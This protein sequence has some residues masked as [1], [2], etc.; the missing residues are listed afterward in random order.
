MSLNDCLNSAVQQG[1]ISRDQADEINKFYQQKIR[2]KGNTTSGRSAAKKE[3][4]EELRA[5]AELARRR[6]LLSEKARRDIVDFL[7][8]HHTIYG[9]E[10]KLDGALSLMIHYGNVG[11]FSMVGRMHAIIGLAHRSLSDVMYHFRKSGAW[12]KYRNSIDLPDLVR[13]IHG[14]AV[15]NPAVKKMA[16]AIRGAYEDL[17]QRFNA[18]G[19]NIPKRE[20]HGLPHSHDLRKI[21]KAGGGDIQKSRQAWK[22][23]IRPLLDPEMM[24]NPYTGQKIGW[25]GLDASLDH[26]FDSISSDNLAHLDP[27]SRALGK[28]S[29]ANRHQDNRFL[30]FRDAEAWLTYNERFGKTDV[31]SAIFDHINGMARDIAAMERFGPNPDATIQWLTQVVQKDIG[32]QMAG[33]K[34]SKLPGMSAPAAAQFRLEALWQKLRGTGTV[35]QGPAK[36]A[37]DIRNVATSAALG[38]TGIL[39]S[40]TDPFVASAA[41]RLAGLPIISQAKGVLRRF[42]DDGD[43]RAMARAGMIWEDFMYTANENARY[44]GELYGNEWSKWVVDRALTWNAL[45]PLTDARKRA[46]AGAWFSELGRLAEADTDWIDVHPLL[47]KTME[48]FGFTA[49]DWHAMRGATDAA[50]F[51]SPG[52]IMTNTKRRDLAEKLGEMVTQWSERSVPSGDP[53]IETY[54]TGKQQRGTIAGEMMLFAKQFMSF[55]MSFTAR[56]ME[57]MHLYSMLGRSRSSKIGRGAFYFTSMAVPLT[58]GAAFY[59]QVSNVISGKDPED[60]SAP[61]FWLRAFVKGGG[62]GLFADF[63]AKSENR[64][65]QGIASTL[66][67]IGGGFIGDT[68][69]LASRAI[70]APFMAVGGSEE[71][72]G[73][74]KKLPP[75]LAR[76]TPFISTHPFTRVAWQRMF[77]DQLQWLTDPQAEESF[78]AKK[79]SASYWWEPG[80][81]L[82]SRLPDLRN[83]FGEVNHVQ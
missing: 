59:M 25:S 53:R 52:S 44:V 41:R 34:G 9:K 61:D 66:G 11:T 5:K 12:G 8:Q 26:V 73:F 14:E 13:G 36:I 29:L 35:W 63:I 31:I 16:I 51:L 47:K 30:V 71:G 43:R 64:Y 4:V 39:S 67:G 3:A 20:D 32:E 81:G 15:G 75:Y 77:V 28:G 17:R 55:G 57:A 42:A 18:A 27:A 65:G 22:D 38:A 69:D 45:K 6:V 48:G 74:G 60:M 68:A 79:R 24:S 10:S 1:A 70:R 2:E 83:A 78:K 37:T 23:F 54:V 21:R 72:S 50:G 40:V 7:D 56:Q 80:R 82:P 62:G 19:G 46:E 76:Y 33:K 49:D 58:F